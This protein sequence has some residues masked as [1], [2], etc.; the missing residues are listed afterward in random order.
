MCRIYPI[1][2]INIESEWCTG[3]IE[4]TCVQDLIYDMIVGNRRL[5]VHENE[6]DDVEQNEKQAS[7][8]EMMTGRNTEDEIQSKEK[9]LRIREH[10]LESPM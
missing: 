6:R 2:R 8:N 7:E 4:A 9:K 3:N 10:I 1:A 5:K